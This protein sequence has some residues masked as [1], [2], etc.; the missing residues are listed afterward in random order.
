MWMSSTDFSPEKKEPE[1]YGQKLDKEIYHIVW[2]EVNVSPWIL[3]VNTKKHRNTTAVDKA[4]D[5]GMLEQLFRT[6]L[7]R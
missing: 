1:H 3:C 6:H 4:R 5:D 7:P 2:F